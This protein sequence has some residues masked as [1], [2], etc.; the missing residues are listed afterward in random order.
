MGARFLPVGAA[1]RE[2][3]PSA[4]RQT[5]GSFVTF[6]DPDG[7][8]WIVQEITTRMPGRE[9]ARPTWT[10]FRPLRVTGVVREAAAVSSIA[11]T[12]PDGSP[13]PAA[14][15]GQ[16]LTLRIPGLGSPAPVRSYSLSSAPGAAGYRISVKHEPHGTVSGYLTAA[17]RPGVVLDAAA[18][19]GEFVLDHATGPVL[20][21]SAGIGVTPVLAMLH[22]L[23]AGASEREV[24]WIHGDRGPPTMAP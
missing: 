14:Q 6:D 10:G 24:W 1:E 9:V 8:N 22:E 5:Y 13:L 17:V 19:R 18:P 21:I 4:N 7:N 23:A 12:T 3:G 16:Y 20:L 2:P 15:A 11:L